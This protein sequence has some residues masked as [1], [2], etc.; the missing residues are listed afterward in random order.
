MVDVIFLVFLFFLYINL[1]W[2]VYL[3]ELLLEY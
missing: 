2:L 1:R 3:L